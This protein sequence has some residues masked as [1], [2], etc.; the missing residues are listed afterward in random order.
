[1]FLCDYSSANLRA[2]RL[3]PDISICWFYRS[4][5][6]YNDFYIESLYMVVT[7]I[8]LRIVHT[9]HCEQCFF[10]KSEIWTNFQKSL[11]SSAYGFENV[12]RRL[13]RRKTTPYPIFCVFIAFQATFFQKS[14]IMAPQAKFFK[15]WLRH[16]GITGGALEYLIHPLLLRQLMYPLLRG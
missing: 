15:I 11:I 13:W 3:L 4:K 14:L 8:L 2:W 16:R 10:R 1:M 12:F 5:I 7:F 9:L 6:E